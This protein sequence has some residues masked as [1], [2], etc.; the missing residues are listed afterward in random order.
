MLIQVVHCHPL[1]ESYDH[2]LFRTIVQ[3][4]EQNGHRVIPTDLYREGFDPVM[5]IEERRSYMGNDY[6]TSGVA[7]YVEI[8]K[9]VEGVILC[10][11]HWWFSMPAKIKD[12][13]DR[14]WGP[15]VAFTYDPNDGH[16]VPDLRNVRLVGV[17]TSYGS[18]WWIVKIF[19]G[20][21]GRMVLMRGMKPLC[22]KGAQSF[23][24]AKYA[25]D[26]STP[27]SRQAFMEKVRCRIAA[28][29]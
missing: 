1:T 29:A 2:A 23:Y 9:K 22:A 26:S 24:L 25:M 12:W 15:G 4:L 21:A 14:V 8:L 16:L 6:D 5:T 13:V 20:D 18:P 28:I 10:F 17:V 11:P 3:T 27:Q 19:A 7:T